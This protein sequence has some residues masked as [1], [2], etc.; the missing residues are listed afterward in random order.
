MIYVALIVENSTVRENLR[1]TAVDTRGMDFRRSRRRWLRVAGLAITACVLGLYA[2]GTTATYQQRLA[3]AADHAAVGAAV[4]EERVQRVLDR[5]EKLDLM[6]IEPL[7]AE[8]AGES[9]IAALLNETGEVITAQ[10]S[11]ASTTWIAR[12]VAERTLQIPMSVFDLQRG[13]GTSYIAH[14]RPVAGWPLVVV[15]A[16]SR[17]E[18]LRPLWP[19]F[20]ASAA[21]ALLVAGGILGLNELL[22]REVRQRRVS[23]ARFRDF[24]ESTSDWLWELNRELRFIY[25]SPHAGVHGGGALTDEVG[26]TRR[27]TQP[28]VSEALL[29]AHEDDLAQRRP[30]RNFT[31]A[32]IDDSGR[33]RHIS[34]SGRPFF[35]ESG[36]FQGYRGTGR[37]ITAEIEAWD[38][39]AKA[40]SKLDQ[41]RHLLQAIID[42]VPAAISVKD[43]ELRYILVNEALKERVLLL[44]QMPGGQVLGKRSTQVFGEAFGGQDEAIDRRVI[45]TGKPVPFH[46]IHSA[47]HDGI[48]R[49]F[50]TTRQPLKLDEVG[51][52][53]I[54]S[55]AIDVTEQRQAES[56]L[57]DAI[58]AINAGFAM[59][60]PSDRLVAWNRRYADLW[61]ASA[62]PALPDG[63]ER[64]ARLL[65][66]G[67][68]FEDLVRGLG[69]AGTHMASGISDK[70]A[71]VEGRIAAHEAPG[72]PAELRI[73]NSWIRISN[74]RTE[75]G[76]YVTLMT[77][78]TQLKQRGAELAA[79]SSLLRATL[80]SLGEGVAVV[81]FS[82]RLLAWNRPYVQLVGLPVDF[83]GGTLADAIAEQARAGEI[84]PDSVDDVLEGWRRAI[85]T[86]EPVYVERRRTDG[87][88]I[89]LA[90]LPVAGIGHVIAV[91]DVTK[92]RRTM[93]QLQEARDRAESS[94]RAK[95]AFLANMSHELRTPLNAILGFAEV[96]EQQLLGPLGSSRYV[97]YA[98]DIRWSGNHLLQL[99][100]DVLDLSKI[101]AGR[102]ELIEE[103]LDV[104]GLARDCVHLLDDRA[105]DAGV[106]WHEVI[107][108]ELPSLRADARGVRQILLNL[109]TNAVKFTGSG[110]TV[111]FEARQETGG[112]PALTIA[113]TG[114]G[115]PDSELAHIFEPFRYRSNALVSR[116]KEGTG[117]GLSICKRLVE[118]HGGTIELKSK[119]DRGTTVTVRFPASQV[120]EPVHP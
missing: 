90:G 27:E 40:Q 58:E 34:V 120:V 35:N 86:R 32:R 1:E 76:G 64:I 68:R 93:L 18:A 119:I 5:S 105:R 28:L 102:A 100:N 108:T 49:T 13:D 94:N 78:I 91:R 3:M 97:N 112:G 74:H 101:E 104:P 118:M 63:R 70:D 26:K 6:S 22:I 81:D 33:R 52:V 10:P 39:A 7:L 65:R 99:I 48:D 117:L 45:E 53:S 88:H 67:I 60:D 2:W 29:A 21:F 30:F 37:D 79:Q 8:L 24:A 114:M 96:M 41:Q 84:D 54:L 111:T 62:D 92:E 42:T 4:I 51:T 46:E 103:V 106:R 73:E 95:S 61:A 59:F 72:T 12:A 20:V 11:L 109:L 82:G 110:G 107:P 98:A 44:A 15:V 89:E 25:V 115:I 80:E 17:A 50:L 36:A 16:D 66:R 47:D 38:I 69:D 113:D 87:T 55:V 43:K 14:Y 75:D 23:E 19:M 57:K 71:W 9:G 83:A 85:A 77:D 56:R 116:A 31:F